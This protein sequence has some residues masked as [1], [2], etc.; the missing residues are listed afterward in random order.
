MGLDR[1]TTGAECE[2]VAGVWPIPE[3]IGDRS[4]EALRL[5]AGSPQ[6]ATAERLPAQVKKRRYGPIRERIGNIVARCLT[7]AIFN[8]PF[9]ELLPVPTISPDFR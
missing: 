2:L 1:G 3:F 7:N 4:W 5:G 8:V 9:A 6:P